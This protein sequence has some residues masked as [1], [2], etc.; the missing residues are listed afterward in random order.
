MAIN[1][2]TTLHTA[3]A[4]WL[5]RTDLTSRIP[6][7]IV[8]CEAKLRRELRALDMETTTTSFSINAEFVNVPT[9]FLAVRSFQTS[10]GGRRYSLK[11]LPDEAQTNNYPD[12]GAPQFYSVVGSQFRFAPR[13][14][15]TYTA[16]LVY[17]LA[18][19]ALN[20]TPGSDTNWILTNH[21][22]AYLYG[23]L[24]EAEAFLQDDP[25]LPLWKTGYD[26]VIASIKKSNRMNRWSGPGL[27]Q[28]PG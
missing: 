14:D 1:T 4:N 22:D 28:V 27:A 15:A 6:E 19:T 18:F 7:F 13:P 11:L 5:A 8:L 16:T 24:L 12:T 23:S 21:P 3:I 2:G 20:P 9:S 25:R 10:L 26:E 17:Y